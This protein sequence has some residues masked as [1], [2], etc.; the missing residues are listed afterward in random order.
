MRDK[1]R[2][3]SLAGALI[4]A[5]AA[6][7]AE[8]PK[9]TPQLI[10]QGKASFQRN[11][12]ACHGD[13]GAGDGPAAAA[14]NPKP[15]N[16]ATEPFKNGSSPA[17]VFQTIAKGLPGTPMIAFG[18]LSEDERWGLAYYVAELRSKPKKK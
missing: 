6:G 16:L 4:V 18:H 8:A 14:L 17:Q 3:S 13:R 1:M 10:D 12:A 2:M 5:F 11:C 9:K 15:R 7:A